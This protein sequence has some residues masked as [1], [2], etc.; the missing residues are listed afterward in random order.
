[1]SESQLIHLIQEVSGQ[2][3][4]LQLRFLFLPDVRDLRGSLMCASPERPSD[5]LC[6]LNASLRQPD[7]DATDFLDGP[8][9]QR[10]RVLGTLRFVFWGVVAFA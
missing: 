10:R 5:D 7:G 2:T 1:M 9:D 8:A 4:T 6:R 3:L